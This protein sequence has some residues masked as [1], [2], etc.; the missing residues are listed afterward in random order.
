MPWSIHMHGYWGRAQTSE[1]WRK[2]FA[3]SGF[4]VAE[5]GTGPAILYW[6]VTRR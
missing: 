1:R 5:T 6:L 2:A 4:D 3:G